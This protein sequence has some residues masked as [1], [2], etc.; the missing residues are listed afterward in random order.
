MASNHETFFQLGSFALVGRSANKPFPIL[1]YRRLK[2]LGKT[3]YAVDPSTSKIDGDPSFA[4]LASL[5]GAVEGLIIE[6]PKQE[7]ADWVA[8][9]ADA[10]IKD[11]WIHMAHD[12]PEAVATARERGINLRTGTCAV[13]YLKPGLTYHSI[14]KLIMKALGKY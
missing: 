1:S 3:V 7:C 6:T 5:P 8:R 11:V 10:G 12:T 4:D 2:K 13:M 14:H 9:A